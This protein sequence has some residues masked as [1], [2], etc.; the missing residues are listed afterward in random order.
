MPVHGQPSGIPKNF[1]GIEKERAEFHCFTLW[2][3]SKWRV[4]F[5]GV[6]SGR[7]PFVKTRTDKAVRVSVNAERPTKS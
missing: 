3:D 1:N 5:K 6:L 2:K 4:D 7:A